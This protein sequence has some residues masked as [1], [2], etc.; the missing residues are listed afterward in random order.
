MTDDKKFLWWINREI[1][2]YLDKFYSF[3]DFNK[4]MTAA[5]A[6]G[7]W[8]RI[9]YAMAKERWRVETVHHIPL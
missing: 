9:A 6:S 5:A 2:R 8:K 7:E 3:D 4:A 1:P